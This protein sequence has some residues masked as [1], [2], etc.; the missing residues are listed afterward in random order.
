MFVLKVHKMVLD[1]KITYYKDMLINFTRKN[2][3]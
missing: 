2:E 3:L 1:I